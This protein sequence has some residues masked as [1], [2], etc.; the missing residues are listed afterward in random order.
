MSRIDT[1]F[2]DLRANQK[3]AVMPYITAGDPC[4]ETTAELIK[5]IDA[6]GASVIE[7]GIPFSD[8]I[9]D[10]PTIQAA[11]TRALDGGATVEGAFEAVRSVRDDISCGLVAMASFS[12]VY[13][14]GLENFLTRAK[15]AGF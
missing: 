10:G 5:A 1:I 4:M 3:K 7:I 12:I 9:A 8:P 6:A 2:A 13:C 11:M 14:I 15:A